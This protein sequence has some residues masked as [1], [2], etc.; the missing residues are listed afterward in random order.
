M[1]LTMFCFIK[2]SVS[3]EE[4]VLTCRV[5]VGELL[6]LCIHPFSLSLKKLI[7]I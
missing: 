7:N 6:E 1:L 2:R 5:K 3:T 4:S